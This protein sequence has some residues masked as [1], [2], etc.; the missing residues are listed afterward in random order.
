M[1]R[2]I[3]QNVSEGQDCKLQKLK[4][5]PTS[6]W[7]TFLYGY[8]WPPSERHLSSNS[9]S[10]TS[11]SSTVTVR[12]ALSEKMLHHRQAVKISVLFKGLDQHPSISAHSSKM[13]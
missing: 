11:T 4:T 3:S 6:A 10:S 2:K 1:P 12:S 5:L 7:A 9:K 8:F 13:L